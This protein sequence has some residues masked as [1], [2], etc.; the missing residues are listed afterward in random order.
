MIANYFCKPHTPAASRSMNPPRILTHTQIMKPLANPSPIRTATKH[1]PM[2]NTRQS[3][4]R[5][6]QAQPPYVILRIRHKP[7]LREAHHAECSPTVILRIGYKPSLRESHHAEPHSLRSAP[8]LCR[9]ASLPSTIL[10]SVLPPSASLLP[11]LGFWLPST[12]RS[13]SPGN[14]R[15]HPFHHSTA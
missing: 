11:G 2:R 14:N 9:Y 10:R 4:G 5:A 8:A 15:R 13:E 6:L 12:M 3:G 7:S 1:Y